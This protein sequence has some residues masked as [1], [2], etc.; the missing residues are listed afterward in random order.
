MLSADKVVRTRKTELRRLLTNATALSTWKSSTTGVT[1]TCSC[2]GMS[3]MN[4]DNHLLQA[5][6]DFQ[7][8]RAFISFFVQA[9]KTHHAQLVQQR[10]RC[11]RYQ[12]INVLS[13]L[14]WWFLLFLSDVDI[15]TVDSASVRCA[16]TGCRKRPRPQS[17]NCNF[18]PNVDVMHI[19]TDLT[20]Q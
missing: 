15:F 10:R 16:S 3:T 1:Q 14:S 5:G 8:A 6:H 17:I 4:F 2:P 13:Q 7:G 19:L 11:I 18:A 9:F 12:V 20:S